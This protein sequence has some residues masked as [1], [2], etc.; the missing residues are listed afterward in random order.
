MCVTATIKR[1]RK[2]AKNGFRGVMHP[3]RRPRTKTTSAA[4][5]ERREAQRREKQ[6]AMQSRK[7]SG[8]K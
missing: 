3:M 6:R 1:R 7:K 5:L 4:V 8:K 2:Q